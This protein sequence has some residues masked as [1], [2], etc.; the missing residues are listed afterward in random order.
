MFNYAILF[1]VNSSN[2]CY[3]KKLAMQMLLQLGIILLY[4]WFARR[5][6]L[7]MISFGLSFPFVYILRSEKDKSQSYKHVFLLIFLS[8]M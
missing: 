3:H 4:L 6:M 5:Q 7:L 8:M 2:V 1:H